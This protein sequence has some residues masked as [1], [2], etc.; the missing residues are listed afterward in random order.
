MTNE[1]VFAITH[2]K[3]ASL[4][5]YGFPFG[6]PLHEAMEKV[7]SSVHSKAPRRCHRGTRQHP[8]TRKHRK[9]DILTS[10]AL[11]RHLC[12]SYAY[13]SFS[14]EIYK[15]NWVKQGALESSMVSVNVKSIGRLYLLLKPQYFKHSFSFE[16][17]DDS[18]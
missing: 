5:T 6:F 15:K 4:K 1:P 11:P 7:L 18:S 2:V 10:R 12:H 9:R 13:L 3:E 16:T 14:C 8:H 17:P